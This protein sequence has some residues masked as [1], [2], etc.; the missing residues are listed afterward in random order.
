M[1]EGKIFREVRLRALLDSP[2]AFK[3]TH[4]EALKRSSASWSEQ[5]DASAAGSER[6]TYLAL[7]GDHV[8]GI[9]ALYRIPGA[10]RETAELMQVWVDPAYRKQGI[11]R[12]LQT[13]LLQWGQTYNYAVIIATIHVENVAVMGFYEK[14][15][16]KLDTEATAEQP[17]RD[18]ILRLDLD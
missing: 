4:G 15:G 14:T 13:E 17:P 7:Q 12:D 5:C 2:L 1:G 9:A 11:A 3:S 6:C 16:F 8:V 18:I 10:V